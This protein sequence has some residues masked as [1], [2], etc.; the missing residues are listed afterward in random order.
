[1]SLKKRGQVTIFIIL[2]IILLLSVMLFLF[3]RREVSVFKPEAV[4]PPEIVPINQYILDCVEEISRDG[5]RIAGANAGFI[6][7]PTEIETNP[8]AYL[9]PFPISPVKTPLWFYRGQRRV[10]PLNYIVFQLENYIHEN[11]PECLR[12]FEA[13]KTAFNITELGNISV[14]IELSEEDFTVNI[15]YPLDIILKAKE[16]KFFLEDFSVSIPFR[17]RKMYELAAQILDQELL[18]SF[19]ETRTID[20]IAMDP[21]I[22][23]TGAE[24]SCQPKTWQM[25]D[26]QDKLKRLLAINLPRLAVEKTKYA[27]IPK[28]YPYEQH[29]NIWEV[30]DIKY[31]DTHVTFSYD[32]AWP[33]ELFI[34]PSQGKTLRSNANRGQEMLS[35]MCM[36][37]WHFT[38]DVRYPVLVTLKDDA[39]GT[40]EDYTFN[41]GFDVSINHN[42]PD[43]SNFA[44]MKFSFETAAKESDYCAQAQTNMLTVHTFEN[45]STEE[46]GDLTTEIDGVNITY[47]CMRMRCP[48][49]QSE[50]QFR[51]A[52]S[53]ISAEVPSCPNGV[54]RGEKPGYEPVEKFASVTTE[55]SMD[56]YLTPVIEIPIRV[57]KHYQYSPEQELELTE[58]DSAFITVRTGSFDSDA[59]YSVNAAA[60]LKLLAKWDYAY[61]LTVLLADDA[62][63]RGG[64]KAVWPVEWEKL[65]QAKEIV[66]HVFE[67]PYIDP[68][69][70]PEES[71]E[72]LAKLEQFVLE[73]NIPPPEIITVIRPK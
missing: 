19:L 8:E 63:I 36:Q 69:Q 72:T 10:P 11:L 1:M 23:Y 49:G 2:G 5:A 37:I 61:N 27:P 20:L 15:N 68:E 28:Q 32:E 70:N 62:T 48:V 17:I 43:K 39:A 7:L 18:T 12:E 53:Y 60:A 16:Q 41:F 45:V 29:H 46:I 13:F 55:T 30:T 22:P 44:P 24:F 26:V 21:K 51:G 47:T 58:E 57:V 64:Y 38:Y 66:F 73:Y 65:K 71:A 3:L 56:L 54:L 14:E 40:H 25:Q 59:A 4:L 9:P 42:M 31:P 35:F 33:F 34:R 6:E 50:W 52:V 67:R